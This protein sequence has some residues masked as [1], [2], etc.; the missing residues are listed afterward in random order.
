MSRRRDPNDPKGYY[1]ML[2]VRHDA[3][4]AEIKKAYKKLGNMDYYRL[5][6]VLSEILLE[7]P[8]LT[9]YLNFTWFHFAAIKYHPDKNPDNPEAATEMFKKVSEAYEHIGDA[10]KRQLYD[11]SSLL[12][13]HLL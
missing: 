10:D 6:L 9:L 1:E 2:D 11:V 5:L 4:E 13:S 3:S 7:S 8:M 12:C